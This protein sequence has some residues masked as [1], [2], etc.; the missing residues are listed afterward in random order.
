MDYRRSNCFY[1]KYR[2][3]KILCRLLGESIADRRWN[4][5]MKIGEQLKRLRKEKG[6][7]QKELANRSGLS[8]SFINQVEGG[9][10]SVR[11]DVLSRLAEAFG[12]EIRLV[13]RGSEKPVPL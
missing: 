1:S 11:L 5:M 6:L 9:K 2:P 4:K 12:Y 10:E 7:T 3:S 8:F 13:K